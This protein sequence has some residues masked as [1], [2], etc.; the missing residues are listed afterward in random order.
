MP[1]ARCRPRHPLVF[2]LL[3]VGGA[4]CVVPVGPQFQDP[5]AAPNY[6]PQITYTDPPEGRLT[7][8]L[9]FDITVADP[10]VGDSL[11]VRLIADPDSQKG[12]SWRDYPQGPSGTPAPR[13]LEA[14]NVACGDLAQ[15]GAEDRLGRHQII[16]VVAD[17]R[18]RL[19]RPE[20]RAGPGPGTDGHGELDAEPVMS[21]HAMRR[22]WPRGLL[23]AALA[24]GG[25]CGEPRVVGADGV[26][27]EDGQCT[28]GNRC[29]S[30]TCVPPANEGSTWAV[31]ILPGRGTGASDDP[32]M[33]PAPVT[34]I[35]AWKSGEN[36][37]LK[38][39]AT[40]TLSVT[41]EYPPTAVPPPL[42]ANVLWTVPPVIPGRP[43]LT[44]ETNVWPGGANA[45]LSVP[46]EP[47]DIAPRSGLLQLIPWPTEGGS[48]PYSFDLSPAE[49]RPGATVGNSVSL[50]GRVQSAFGNVPAGQFV[51]QAFQGDR[52]VS[53]SSAVD[54]DGRFTLLVPAA[55]ATAPVTLALIPANAETDPV[56]VLNK[57][58]LPNTSL[59][60]KLP[61]YL[62]P[63]MP[64][65]FRVRLSDS[66]GDPVDQG[67]LVT[68]R[69]VL[70]ADED[71]TTVF[72]QS[73]VASQRESAL[74]TLLPGSGTGLRYS[75]VVS[76]DVTSKFATKCSG[77]VAV[78]AGNTTPSKAPD[79]L[80]VTLVQ[81]LTVSGTVVNATGSKETNVGRV[82]NVVVTA[83][84]LRRTIPIALPATGR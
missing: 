64:N 35:E 7:S 53:N 27:K 77:E 55:V 54:G 17:S 2:A 82:A 75:F 79:I 59:D 14:I 29:V 4:G 9:K 19:R 37:Q 26:C 49:H 18:L 16:V 62:S 69:A 10:N 1:V 50:R 30:G 73:A 44:F 22:L 51:A 31:E 41:L 33:V 3:A 13:T 46:D 38:A 71:S 72:V 84:L 56:F 66:H 24:V 70:G 43:D 57:V 58:E 52:L 12:V 76:P 34:E 42:K 61:S 11:F 39:A 78:F 48:P 28:E 45:L 83:T 36:A 65:Y 80:W 67:I 23:A 40:T 5:L 8:S 60:V 20:T 47:D 6:P 74:L 15:S 32:A 81:R 63:R 68:A 25:A 21:A